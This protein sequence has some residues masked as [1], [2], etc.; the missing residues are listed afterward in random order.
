M[1]TNKKIEEL[2]TEFYFADRMNNDGRWACNELAEFVFEKGYQRTLDV[3][4]D[5]VENILTKI[6]N[7]YL[8][9]GCVDKAHAIYYAITKITEKYPEVCV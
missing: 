9:N 1:N 3:A 6:K 2:S 5:I 4:N 8:S 7:E